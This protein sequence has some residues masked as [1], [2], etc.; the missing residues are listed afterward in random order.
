MAQQF[1]ECSSTY[2]I[3]GVTTTIFQGKG[4]LHTIV[5]PKATTG[6]VTVQ[7]TATSPTNYFVLPVGTVGTF[8]FDCSLAN[9]LAVVTTAADATIVN[10]LQ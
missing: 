6:T 7:N 3:T 4:F 9:G 10:W 5:I 2:I 1:L 8:T